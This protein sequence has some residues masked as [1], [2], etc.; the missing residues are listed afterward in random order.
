MNKEEAKKEIIK[1]Y[2]YIYENVIYI[3]APYVQEIDSTFLGLPPKIIRLDY[4]PVDVMQLLEIFLFTDEEMEDTSFYRLIEEKK[5]DHEYLLKV[6]E[7]LALLKQKNDSTYPALREELNAFKVFKLVRKFIDDQKVED[8]NKE[9][10][11]LALD[12]YFRI[13]RYTN[14]SNIWIS[15]AELELSDIR[16]GIKIESGVF[17]RNK[18]IYVRSILDFGIRS[19]TFI[20]ILSNK[21]NYGENNSFISEE[22]KAN[23][24]FTYHDE[25][26]WNRMT[27]CEDIDQDL[28]VISL[29]RPQNTSPCKKSFYVREEDIFVKE[30]SPLY[31]YYMICPHCGYIVSVPINILTDSTITRIEDRCRRD[32]NLFRKMLLYSELFSLDTDSKLLKK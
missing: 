13:S 2:K 7:G 25:I 16:N 23:I 32:K 19:S 21:E 5:N 24:Y 28:E 1:R 11:L 6:K 10:K 20:N 29:V 26:P 4:L 30:D 3:L 17:S 18:I 12:E 8:E 9:K 14:D 15:G 31:R 22:E 27:I